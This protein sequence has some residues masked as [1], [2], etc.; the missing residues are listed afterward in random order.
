MY[1]KALDFIYW[2]EMVHLSVYFD[3]ILH[4][5]TMKVKIDLI[6]FNARSVYI[7]PKGK[8][9]LHQTGMTCIAFESIL[10]D[11]SVKF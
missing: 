8:A 2:S 5:A 6:Y 9:I 4:L 1:K 11:V 10:T 7:I 3:N